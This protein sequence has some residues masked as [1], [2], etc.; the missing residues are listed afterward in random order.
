MAKRKDKRMSG[1]T[2]NVQA[3]SEPQGEV[4][5]DGH[6]NVEQPTP[7]QE[8][9]PTA[10]AS[11][12]Q[13]TEGETSANGE[14]A[15]VVEP[16]KPKSTGPRKITAEE[17][18]YLVTLGDNCFGEDDPWDKT[19][20]YADI[21]E[22]LRD[23]TEMNKM[24]A[25]GL[26]KVNMNGPLLESVQF[27]DIGFDFSEKGKDEATQGSSAKIAKEKGEAAGSR[28]SYADPN[29]KIK[30]LVEGNP[31]RPESHGFYSFQLYKDGMTYKEY[32]DSEYDDSLPVVGTDIGFIGPNSNQFKWDLEH[33]FIGVYDSR[34]EEDSP[35]YWVAKFTKGDR[36][37]PSKPMTDE[38][39]AA[40]KAAKAAEPK[41]TSEKK[42]RK[43]KQTP[44]QAVE[45]YIEVT[46]VE[47]LAPGQEDESVV[48]VAE[49][50]QPAVP[51]E[52]TLAPQP[53]AA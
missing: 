29:Y 13:P 47:E 32:V 16:T 4:V 20:L 7:G 28:M 22:E 33:G 6:E 27:T 39:K 25:R 40:A 30:I 15:E 31:R 11:A 43:K 35:K 18:N 44:E 10:E 41:T 52:Q 8:S 24:V 42:G 9:A 49:G 1:A 38:E 34:E 3:V 46:P 2:N 51:T 21:P 53:A 37:P 23:F 48:V 50:E 45:E 12:E 17:Y 36:A 26:I 14:A 5:A 19:I